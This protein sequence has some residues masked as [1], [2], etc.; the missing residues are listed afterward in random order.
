MGRQSGLDFTKVFIVLVLLPALAVWTIL[1]LYDGHKSYPYPFCHPGYSKAVRPSLAVSE[2]IKRQMVAQDSRHLPVSAYE[3]DHIVP[4][5]LGG[6]PYDLNNLQLQTWDRA[7]VKD[8]L[9]DKYH[10]LVCQGD[11]PLNEA[12]EI[13]KEFK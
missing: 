10:F 1:S 9:E 13:L 12:V 3:L 8:N 6:S 4:I 7:K 5:E 11:M 2:A